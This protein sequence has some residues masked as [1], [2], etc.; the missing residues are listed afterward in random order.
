M[1]PQSAWLDERLPQ[2][3]RMDHAIMVDVAVHISICS[4]WLD[5]TSGWIQSYCLFCGD[6]PSDSAG[7]HLPLYVTI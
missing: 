2:H 3:E 5:I 6:I 4:I 1:E 7:L